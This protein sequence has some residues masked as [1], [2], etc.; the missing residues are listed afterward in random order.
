MP[1]P[2]IQE[3]DMDADEE[4][5]VMGERKGPKRTHVVSDSD[6]ETTLPRKRTKGFKQS[7]TSA[8]SNVRKAL[9]DAI[10]TVDGL[11][12]VL[13]TSETDR[14]ATAANNAAIN[15]LANQLECG[16]CYELLVRPFVMSCGHTACGPC[17][18]SMWKS[19]ARAL[20]E[21]DRLE[22]REKHCP[23]CDKVIRGRPAVNWTLKSL[24]QSAEGKEIIL[25][26]GRHL[27]EE[28]KPSEDLW[29]GIFPLDDAVPG[30]APA[31][32]L[33]AAAA[34]RPPVPPRIAHPA[35]HPPGRMYV[36]RYPIPQA[37]PGR[38]IRFFPPQHPAVNRN[39]PMQFFFPERNEFP[40]VLRGQPGPVRLGQPQPNP[41]QG[42]QFPEPDIAQRQLFADRLRQAQQALPDPLAEPDA[43]RRS[44]ADR[45]RETQLRER[46]LTLEEELVRR[47]QQQ[48]QQAPGAPAA[49]AQPVHPGPVQPVRLLPPIREDQEHMNEAVER[50]MRHRREMAEMLHQEQ[51]Q[52]RQQFLQTRNQ[53]QAQQQ[54]Q[55]QQQ[56]Y[57]QP[58]A[59]QQAQQ[60]QQVPAQQAQ[61]AQQVQNS[62][63][64]R[65][66]PFA[67]LDAGPSRT[68][69]N[70]SL[71][72]QPVPKPGSTP[73][74]LTPGSLAPV[75]GPSA[76]EQARERQRAGGEG[77][78]PVP[79]R[80]TLTAEQQQRFADDMD[81]FVREQVAGLNAWMDGRAR[82]AH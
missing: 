3:V 14:L 10:S 7:L 72:M 2:S 60:Q 49:P 29:D 71:P 64:A 44:L 8:T 58:Q 39:D 9:E 61:Q 76:P 45:M 57:Q 27:M 16:L 36:P 17:L 31:P 37:P 6:D 80:M 11:S 65:M 56:Q 28:T 59:Q 41:N 54:Q 13:D 25:L 20:A 46:A 66:P 33:A 23:Y 15:A 52:R 77:I 79:P 67:L 26:S 51:R 82:Y 75:A 78:M 30:P 50:M 63:Q 21:P 35:H 24:L 19:K 68:G 47:H 55:V 53:Q 73:S 40:G 12:V 43:A 4:I 42:Q 81:A 62:V 32:P 18:A 70:I 5:Q 1:A 69:L 38:E 34:A 22:L 48:Q 74:P